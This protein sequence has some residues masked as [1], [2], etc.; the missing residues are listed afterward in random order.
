MREP[1]RPTTHPWDVAGGLLG[2]RLGHRPGSER[3]NGM[4]PCLRLG[5]GSRLARC[6][7]SALIR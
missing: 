2:V 4:L 1:A 6:A 7:S 5:A 3:H